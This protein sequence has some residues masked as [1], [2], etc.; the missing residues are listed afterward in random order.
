VRATHIVHA[1]PDL[2]LLGARFGGRFPPGKFDH[3]E[4]VLSDRLSSFQ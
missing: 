4:T 1:L 3:L 2:R